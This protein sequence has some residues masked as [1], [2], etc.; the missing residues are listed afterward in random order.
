MS[1]TTSPPARKIRERTPIHR[2]SEIQINR[3]AAGEVIERP[4]AVVKELVE[5]A[6]D[7]G[8]EHVQVS[9]FHGGIERIEVIDDGWGM[10]PEDMNLAV[11]RHCTSKLQDDSLVHILSLGFRGEALPSIGAAARMTLTSRTAQAESAWRL[12]V[13]GGM[14]H[15]IQ[16]SSGL[17]GTHVLV[18]DLFFSTPARR[19]FLKSAQVEAGHVEMVVRRLA[20]SAPDVAFSLTM[21]GKEIFSLPA[22]S[23]MARITALLAE[24]QANPLIDVHEERGPIQLRGYISPPSVHRGNSNGQFV[25]VNGRPVNDTLLKTAIRVA[26]QSV[27]EKGRFPLAVLRLELPPEQVDIN[28]H[29]AKTE[30]RFADENAIRSLV[31]G[32]LRRALDQ[33]AGVSG[34][35]PAF[36]QG[37]RSQARIIYPPR[38]QSHPE[39]LPSSSFVAAYK[40][41]PLK[42]SDGAQAYLPQHH[43]YPLQVRETFQSVPKEEKGHQAALS[44][45]SSVPL[46]HAQESHSPGE[47]Q[48]EPAYP[49]GV[50]IAQV[51]E[52]YIIAVAEDG[53]MILV[54]QHAAHERLM[55]EKLLK[56]YV[57]GGVQSQNLLTPHV[58]KLTHVEQQAL[59]AAQPALLPLGIE[60]EEFGG[61]SLLVRALPSLLKSSEAESLIRDIA[62]ELLETGSGA[63]ELA[64]SKLEQVIARMACHGS[65][66]AGRTLNREEMNSLLRQMEQTPRAGTCSHGRPTWLKFSKVDIEKLFGR[67]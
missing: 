8:A 35:S 61:D 7:A 38:T 36:L 39:T 15:P 47:G 45:H 33:G 32:S 40:G 3:I 24:A 63:E 54:D 4:A 52:T 44:K 49:L 55:H 13:E 42:E 12:K 18:E 26:Y 30:V 48:A 14:L 43:S 46:P 67:R 53:T 57:E 34:V 17:T 29:P 62:A 31:I 65:V 10:T 16:P 60:I 50:A 64:M 51:L 25:M 37:G 9:L 56:Q 1:D 6:L 2:L 41:S 11:E 19:K 5:N 66:R 22:Q 59:L 21:D 23:F 58:V 27:V 28:V 20:L